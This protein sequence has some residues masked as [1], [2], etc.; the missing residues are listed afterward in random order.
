LQNGDLMAQHQD[1]GVLNIVR[2][3]Q[4]RQPTAYSD[5]DQASQAESHEG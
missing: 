3:W 2:P 4:Q 5:E 1:L